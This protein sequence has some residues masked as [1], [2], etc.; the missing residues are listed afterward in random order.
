MALSDSGIR[1]TTALSADV[2]LHPLLKAHM[3][4][5]FSQ[6][7]LFSQTKLFYPVGQMVASAPTESTTAS[8]CGKLTMLTRVESL[9]FACPAAANSFALAAWKAILEFGKSG[10][11]NLFRI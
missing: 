7:V 8:F 6:F 11:V 5:V 3:W 4:A 2:S 9:P 1:I 10:L